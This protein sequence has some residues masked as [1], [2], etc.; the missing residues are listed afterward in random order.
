MGR[1]ITVIWPV[2]VFV[3]SPM[4]FLKSPLVT[5]TTSPSCKGGR[6]WAVILVGTIVGGGISFAS[7]DT[8][9]SSIGLFVSL[10]GGTKRQ[11]WSS[12]SCA[13]TLSPVSNQ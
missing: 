4:R 7:S 3:I 5:M 8:S 10:G 6:C 2:T 1:T 9:K 13:F 12:C 11:S